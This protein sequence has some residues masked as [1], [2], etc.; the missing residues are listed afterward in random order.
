MK[1]KERTDKIKNKNKLRKQQLGEAKSQRQ[2]A[3]ADCGISDESLT[4]MKHKL[5]EQFGTEGEVIRD[6]TIDKMSDILLAYAAPFLDT[7]ETASKAEYE[8]AIMISMT[9]WN[10][11]IIQNGGAKESKKIEKMLKSLMPDAESRNVMKYM[12]ERKQQMYPDN[13]RMMMNYELTEI[14]DGFHLSV[15]STMPEEKTHKTFT[16]KT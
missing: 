6:S 9:L 15:A 12:L 13:K 8:K 16:E 4:R 7:I 5:D 11:A 14:S 10:C 3:E 2:K 1:K